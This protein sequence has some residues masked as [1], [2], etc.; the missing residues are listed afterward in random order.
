MIIMLHNELNSWRLMEP[1]SCLSHVSEFDQKENR[2]QYNRYNE[3]NAFFFK[4]ANSST[5]L[6]KCKEK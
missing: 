1:K 2:T 6:E 5:S 3:A 4:V